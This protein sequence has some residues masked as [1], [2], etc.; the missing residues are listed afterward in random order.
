LQH[1]VAFQLQ[2]LGQQLAE[3]RFVV[4]DEQGTGGHYIGG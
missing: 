3:A 4:D 2:H 1:G